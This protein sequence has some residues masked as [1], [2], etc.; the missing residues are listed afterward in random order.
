MPGKLCYFDDVR[1][2]LIELYLFSLITGG[3]LDPP[4]GED[5]YSYKPS[6][7]L[8]PERQGEERLEAENIESDANKN[9]KPITIHDEESQ[10]NGRQSSIFDSGLFKKKRKSSDKST[11]IKLPD[12]T[13]SI[14]NIF[15]GMSATNS[16]STHSNPIITYPPKKK[17]DPRISD[18]KTVR[19]S[20]P[21]KDRPRKSFNDHSEPYFTRP[22]GVQRIKEKDKLDPNDQPKPRSTDAADL[23]KLPKD[24]FKMPVPIPIPVPIT[25]I[26]IKRKPENIATNNDIEVIK[27]ESISE[28]KLQDQE[29]HDQEP[30]SEGLQDQELHDPINLKDTEIFPRILRTKSASGD[31]DGKPVE[32]PQT[33]I[34]VPFSDKKPTAPNEFDTMDSS[35]SIEDQSSNETKLQPINAKE[36]DNNI[37]DSA[38]AE[39]FKIPV[40]VPF[41]LDTHFEGSK[42]MQQNIKPGL[43][44][45]Q[46][47]TDITPV[48][49]LTRGGF[50]DQG[51]D[52]KIP[53][54]LDI[55]LEK[56]IKQDSEG[57]KNTDGI[58]KPARETDVKEKASTSTN[59]T[60][61]DMARDS[62][63]KE[64]IDGI[65]KP[66]EQMY[67]QEVKKRDSHG[68]K[69][70]D[71]IEKPAKQSK[72]KDGTAIATKYTEDNKKRDFKED[73]VTDEI[74]K[75]TV[76][77]NTQ[78]YIKAD[79]EG[80]QIKYEHTNTKTPTE[81]K[82]IKD[83]ATIPR[84]YIYESDIK[85]DYEAEAI[86]N[87]IVKLANQ[88]AIKE[89]DIGYKATTSATKYEENISDIYGMPDIV[90]TQQIKGTPKEDDHKDSEIISL[91]KLKGSDSPDKYWDD[92]EHG[93]T[94]L[95]THMDKKRSSL[96]SEPENETDTWDKKNKPYN[97]K[98]Y[99]DE[100]TKSNIIAAPVIIDK[101]EGTSIFEP[102]KEVYRDTELVS[103]PMDPVD[104]P[105]ITQIASE[106]KKFG[107]YE[108]VYEAEENVPSTSTKKQVETIPSSDKRVI[109]PG[110]TVIS[111]VQSASTIKSAMK[112]DTISIDFGFHSYLNDKNER[113]VETFDSANAPKRLPSDSVTII[114]SQIR[115]SSEIRIPVDSEHDMSIQIK[116][117]NANRRVSLSESGLVNVTDHGRVKKQRSP[118]QCSGKQIII[119]FIYDTEVLVRFPIEKV[120]E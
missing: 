99:V 33:S 35:I 81:L 19:S 54:T 22:K 91:A 89:K 24:S 57:E 38:Q 68:E 44:K 64:I 82:N 11:N 117:V 94:D 60:E 49:F 17:S 7:R 3:C 67:T 18:D 98:E 109:L 80:E 102:I 9:K 40:A 113:I 16:G 114:N 105:L 66:L 116:K 1:I 8:G 10:S 62:K 50:S 15:Q 59:Y 27:K 88:E 61:E 37:E 69:N 55:I 104:D 100:T 63:R 36:T 83:T 31:I 34:L 93:D 110:G 79:S 92:I 76:Q 73:E 28:L 115:I 78:D 47:F 70:T 106:F 52:T 43:E 85:R 86:T 65:G 107:D 71:G 45:K 48:N 120:N 58:E 12:K 74:E 112:K 103:Q 84:I 96:L 14:V 32:S 87:G 111:S 41:S 77:E 23:K 51:N 90:D 29:L 20:G 119:I 42:G 108:N 30:Q 56:D 25:T 75:Q 13:D 53:E 39:F 118:V 5:R 95:D 97:N 72:I 46:S 101:T 4:F 26:S 2:S 21:S 6:T